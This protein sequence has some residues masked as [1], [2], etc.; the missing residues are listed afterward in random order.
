VRTKKNSSL[1]PK[2]RAYVVPRL[3]VFQLYF[4]PRYF[5]SPFS[6]T[7]SYHVLHT[8]VLYLTLD[9]VVHVVEIYGYPPPP[10]V[11]T[12]EPVASRSF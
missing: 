6:L 2:S 10:L 3:F 9:V 7:R 4:F 11:C 5:A 1:S 8:S 12:G